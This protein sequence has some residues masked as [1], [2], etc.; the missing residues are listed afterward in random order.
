MGA[1]MCKEIPTENKNE[2]KMSRPSYYGNLQPWRTARKM[3]M[4]D[5]SVMPKQAIYTRKELVDRI[6]ELVQMDDFETNDQV[7]ET[8]H[9]MS[10]ILHEYDFLEERETIRISNTV[11]KEHK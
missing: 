7:Q 6:R 5:N 10:Y 3:R 11:R 2:I 1:E 9:F 8:V 4:D